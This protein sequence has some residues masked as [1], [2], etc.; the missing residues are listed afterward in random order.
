MEKWEPLHTAGR[1]VKWCSCCEKQNYTCSM[2]QSF[3]PREME[4]HG[5]SKDPQRAK[6]ILKKKNNAGGLTRADFKTHYKATVI[7]QV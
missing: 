1:N 5:I 7:K 2:T 4:T 6:T 3:T